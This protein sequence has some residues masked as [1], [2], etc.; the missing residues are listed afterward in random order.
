MILYHGTSTQYQIPILKNGLLP[1]SQ[2]GVSNWATIHDGKIESKPYL[3][4]LTNCYPVYFS[5]QAIKESHDLLILKVE[6][7]EKDL[8]P[9]EDF[10]SRVLKEQENLTIPLADINQMVEPRDYQSAAMHSLNYNGI[11][12][13]THVPPNKILDSRIIKACNDEVIMSIGGDSMPVPMNYK[14]LGSCYQKAIETLFT[15]G[16]LDAVNVIRDRWI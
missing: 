1:R 7:D 10:I 13:T 8:F 6:V 16:E 9:D 3:V 12:A 2:T 4:Y 11:A 14:I 15:H 5:L